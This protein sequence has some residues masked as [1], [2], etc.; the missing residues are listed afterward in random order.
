MIQ[1]K[2]AFCM[3]IILGGFGAIFI[4]GLLILL[5]E[6]KQEFQSLVQ[7]SSGHCPEDTV[8]YPLTVMTSYVNIRLNA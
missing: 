1:T 6:K 2:I 5:R 3:G 8:T 7:K 4:I